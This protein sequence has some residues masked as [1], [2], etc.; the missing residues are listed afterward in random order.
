MNVGTELKTKF[1]EPI[2]GLTHLAGVG[3][4]IVGLVVMIRAAIDHGGIWHMLSFI[5]FGVSMILLYL[6]STLYHLLPATKKGVLW[7]KKIDHMMIYILIAGT[8]TPIC[9]IA[10]RGP[11]GWSL[12]GVVWGLAIIGIVFKVYWIHAPRWI[13]TLIYLFMG[14]MCVVAAYPM[15]QAL[16]TGALV[17]LAIG[18][19][20]YTVGAVVYA[21]KKP[22][23]YPNVFGF[24]EIWHLFVMGG[25]FSHFWAV[26]KYIGS[27]P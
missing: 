5:I 14:W 12:F 13:S 4:A 16:P 27:L 8:Y 7:L 19:L 21:L 22:D 26:Y 20:S 18:G 3:L 11:W 1:R 23:P 25:T 6:S 9:F 10:L 17:W 15:S 24:H 2:S